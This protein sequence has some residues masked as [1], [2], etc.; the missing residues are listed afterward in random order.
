MGKLFL[1]LFMALSV[2]TM[3][4]GCGG[5]DAAGAACES[6]ASVCA[7][8]EVC[9]KGACRAPECTT[10]ADCAIQKYCTGGYQCEAGCSADAD[11]RAGQICNT[12]NNSCVAYG[13]RSTELDCEIGQTCNENSGDCVD[14]PGDWCETCQP[15]NPYSCGTGYLCLTWDTKGEGWCFPEVSPQEE[16]PRGFFAYDLGAPYGTICVGD[17]P[18]YVEGGY[19]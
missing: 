14:A 6:D 3:S 11:C 18:Y 2:G 13:C 16:C 10:S 15:S 7:D 19:I 12:T 9:V 1:G 8:G 5:D 17:C 4:S